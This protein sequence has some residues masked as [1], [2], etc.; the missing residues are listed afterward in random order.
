MTRFQ[1]FCPRDINVGLRHLHL[2]KG[3]MIGKYGIVSEACCHCCTIFEPLSPAYI[4]QLP[5]SVNA[6]VHIFCGSTIVS[7]I[8]SRFRCSHARQTTAVAKADFAALKKF[9][10][11]H[12]LRATCT[13][14]S[15]EP[16]RGYLREYFVAKTV[17]IDV[18]YLRRS[19]QKI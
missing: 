18:R 5:S 7:T 10:V 4:S 3:F 8:F 16:V 15:A 6:A 11:A 14:I 9:F 17:F 12:P 1:P 2:Q 19:F 13:P